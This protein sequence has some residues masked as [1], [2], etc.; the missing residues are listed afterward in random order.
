MSQQK[1]SFCSHNK[2]PE[3][4]SPG[5]F[6]RIEMKKK[7]FLFFPPV[8]IKWLT[9]V[10]LKVSLSMQ[11]LNYLRAISIS[12]QIC[13]IHVR[14]RDTSHE[15]GQSWY[16]ANVPRLVFLGGS[17]LAPEA[18]VFAGCE[19]YWSSPNQSSWQRSQWHLVATLLVTIV[20]TSQA[21]TKGGGAQSKYMTNVSFVIRC[22]R[23]QLKKTLRQCPTQ[24]STRRSLFDGNLDNVMNKTLSVSQSP[25]GKG[26]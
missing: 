16:S 18:G 7:T 20:R 10:G 19:A 8:W 15:L 4:L 14:K 1:N 21:G 23:P 24:S 3:S 13:I 22:H 5:S 26:P 12:P 17:V 2:A 11:A 6:I 9:T 25:T